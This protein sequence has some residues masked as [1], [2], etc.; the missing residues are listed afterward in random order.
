MWNHKVL[1]HPEEEVSFSMEIVKKQ[2]SC[3]PRLVMESIAIEMGEMNGH[4]ILNSKTEYNSRCKIPRLAISHHNKVTTGDI[5]HE[6]QEPAEDLS[7]D[8]IEQLFENNK[9]KCRKKGRD[10]DHNTNSHVISSLPASKRRRKSKIICTD[11]SDGPQNVKYSNE[12]NRLSR[13][14]DKVE[15]HKQDSNLNPNQTSTLFPIFTKPNRLV[16][17]GK[18]S[19]KNIVKVAPPKF[20]Y[21]KISDHFRPQSKTSSEIPN[22]P[23]GESAGAGDEPQ[24]SVDV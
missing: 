12:C 8:D 6:P 4:W 13:T 3:F 17:K 14:D 1:H 10:H 9:R 7:T 11:S 5:P 2:Q 19:K 22:D 21:N 20:K 23:G 16:L 24:L 18:R 15:E